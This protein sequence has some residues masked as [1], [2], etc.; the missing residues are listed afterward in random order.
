M[1]NKEK[2]LV[3][4]RNA[5]IKAK[6]DLADQA[7]SLRNIKE[8]TSWRITMPLRVIMMILRGDWKALL[9][10]FY[11]R[12]P[13]L[14][15]AFD[16]KA[17]GFP[18][19]LQRGLG[20][21]IKKGP[22]A[23]IIKIK[24]GQRNNTAIVD[25]ASNYQAWLECH[26]QQD[27]VDANKIL[28]SLQG[29]PQPLISVL[30]PTYN[31]EERFLR[32]CIESVIGQSYQNWELC[33]ADDASSS[34]LVHDI[35]KEYQE[36][37]KRIKVVFRQENGH[38]SASSNS[39]LELV[40]G[41][42]VALL[43]HDDELHEHAL[44]YITE[45]INSKEG[46]QFIY[47]DE[48]KIDEQ[49]NR[50]EPHFKSDWNLDLLYSQN[51]VSHLGVYKSDIVKK[52]GGFRIG[53]EGSQDF[54]LLLR[55]SREIDHK[56]VVHVPK[57]LYHWRMVQG[58]TALNSGEK[59]YTTDAGIKALKDHFE[60]L[61]TSVSIERGFADNLYKISWP[62]V[63]SDGMEPLVSLIIPTHNGFDI[64]K[65]A[66]DSIVNKTTYS[67][68]EII[69]VDN[70]SEDPK[71]LDYFIE[72]ESCDKITVLRYPF[73]FN[74]SAI[75]NF[76]AKQAKG[77][78][79]GLINNDI[80]VINSDWL[81]E[82]VSHALREDIGCVGAKLYYPNDTIQHGGVILGLGGVA[83]HSH[84]GFPRQH[85]G[86][87]RRLQSVQNYSAV[88]AAC[89]IVSKSIFNEV[90]GLNEAD[91]AVAFNDV[92]F[93]L[94]VKDAGYRNVWTPYA[95]LYHHESISRGAEDNP[96]K[97]ARFNR[98]IDYMTTRWGTTEI[99]DFSYNPNLTISK[100]DFGLS[101]PSR[102]KNGM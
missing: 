20:V 11:H 62:S 47:S 81:T 30:M 26:L 73:P 22:R 89:L 12:V 46:V 65:Q 93:C 72:L 8:S 97:L 66:I 87:F 77:E 29:K 25:A 91:L 75:N 14:A 86:Y 68:Y 84:K 6:K 3:D 7:I 49:G 96:E 99:F 44:L 57:V 48:D 90:Y 1:D 82:M 17:G 92:D 27:Q 71:A 52:I 55:Y 69:L 83:C 10:G 38:I 54:D 33:I 45:A 102:Y 28:N 5:L 43:D 60:V 37:D 70:N 53:Y 42:W 4:A 19:R 16:P 13:G 64:T 39:A 63:K 101:F 98:E 32:L 85:P 31:T 35:L 50:N 15:Y 79:L 59:S 51:Y 76:A 88:T 41:D 56:N 21:L 94:K 9:N 80:E 24:E 100:E 2:E 58:S 74:Y 78:L 95:E 61:N 34:L 23:F 40:N 67:N 36:K 18:S